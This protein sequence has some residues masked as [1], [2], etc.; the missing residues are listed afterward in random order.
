MMTA[1]M[2]AVMT[3]A[4]ATTTAVL[5]TAVVAGILPPRPTMASRM[6]SSAAMPGTPL[7]MMVGAVA[8]VSGAAEVAEEVVLAQA[9]EVAGVA[10]EPEV[11]MLV[12]VLMAEV[13][14]MA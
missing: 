1:V 12:A 8:A 5:L 3:V 14:L 2:T 4:A 10:V 7:T 13:H 6:V 9:Q 11:R